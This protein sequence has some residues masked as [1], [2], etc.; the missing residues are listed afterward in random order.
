MAAYLLERGV[1]DKPTAVAMVNM[2]A[3]GYLRIEQGVADYLLS[4]LDASIALEAEEDL[5]ATAL[6]GTKGRSVRLSQFGRLPKIGRQVN[7]LLQSVSEPDLISPHFWFF[8]PG[9]TV[10]MWCFLAALYPEI[11][12]LWGTNGSAGLIFPAFVAVAC[13]LAA[14]RTLPAVVSKIRSLIPGRSPYRMRFVK[15]DNIIPF[16]LLGA[17]ASL[18]VIGWATSAR[19]ALLFGNYVVVSMLAW[20]S[21][22]SPTAQ[23]RAV[24]QQL[25]E[26]RMF[27]DAVDS[28]RINRTNLPNAASAMPEKY[29]GWALALNIEH[30]WGEQ[31]AAAVVSRIGPQSAMESIET[32]LPENEGTSAEIVDLHLR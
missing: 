12:I 29:W 14:I 8:I 3:K 4:R 25:V 18:A 31:F 30:T 22:R 28:D 17:V 10:S 6:F 21:L 5:I 9:L 32:N 11:E 2:A 23:G 13:L 15:R 1:S 27:L 7:E 24:L 20:I 19:F 16:L 26:F